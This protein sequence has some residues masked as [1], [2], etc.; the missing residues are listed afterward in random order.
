MTA[1]KLTCYKRKDKSCY[2]LLLTLDARSD[3][4]LA[5]LSKLFE[6]DI[7]HQVPSYQFI[8]SRIEMSPFHFSLRSVNATFCDISTALL[9][10]NRT[11]ANIPL[12]FVLTNLEMNNYGIRKF[13]LK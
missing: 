6:N 3:K 7:Q 2:S 13:N 5:N 10:I 11:L 1:N 4:R 12:E 9:K 8:W